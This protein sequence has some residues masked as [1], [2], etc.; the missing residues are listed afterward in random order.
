MWHNTCLLE[1]FALI[2]YSGKG[3]ICAYDFFSELFSRKKLKEIM[4]SPCNAGTLRGI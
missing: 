1:L 3:G 4:T 2:E